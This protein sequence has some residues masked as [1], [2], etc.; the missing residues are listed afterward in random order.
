MNHRSVFK[1][2]II[3]AGF[4]LFMATGFLS[5]NVMTSCNA[6]AQLCHCNICTYAAGGMSTALLQVES[7]VTQPGILLATATITAYFALARNAFQDVVE[8]KIKEV[9]NNQTGWWDTFWGYN[10]LPAMKDM[11]RQLTTLDVGGS[12]SL[13]QLADVTDA[14]RTSRALQNF[15]LEASRAQR[16]SATV[17]SG[18]TAAGGML[19]ADTF[20]RAYA[21]QAP[22]EKNPRTANAKGSTSAQGSGQDLK[23]RWDDYTANYCDPD[24]NAGAAGCTTAGANV[25]RDLDVPGEIFE[26]DTIDVTDA[27]TKAATD[28]L[29]E[30]IAD[31]HAN[32][33]VQAAATKSTI[34]RQMLLRGRAYQA[35]RQAIYDAL[36]YV[37][38][39]RIPGSGMKDFADSM[40]GAAGYDPS[41]LSKNPSHNEMMQVMM[42]DRFRTGNYAFSQV[43]EPENNQREAVIQQAFQTMELSDQLDLLDR[44]AFVLAAATGQQINDG[45]NHNEG[46]PTDRPL[47]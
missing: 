43:D 17:C 27:D 37:L 26:K 24:Y 6:R 10:L 8:Q 23:A 36:Y 19:R 34:G 21:A 31:P 18:G 35:R 20:R 9:T 32:D 45:A 33:P 39:N 7:T 13:G 42:A 40:K 38:S 15:Q 12:G 47:K 29:L 3:A 46:Q 28:A 22:A 14:N 30:N 11:T 25:N 2:L 16:P 44:Y 5:V 1:K 41:V 4:L